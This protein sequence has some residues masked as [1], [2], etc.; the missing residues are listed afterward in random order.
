[1]MEKEYYAS[2]NHQNR[3][4]DLRQK[5]N[6]EETVG[7]GLHEMEAGIE[8]YGQTR[9]TGV[10][11]LIPFPSSTIQLHFSRKSARPTLVCS[12]VLYT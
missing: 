11:G 12:V 7:N 4:A 10:E 6:Q 8:V 5:E 9:K 1:M 3:C 2:I